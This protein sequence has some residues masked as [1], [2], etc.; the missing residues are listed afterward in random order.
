MLDKRIFVAGH[1]GLAGSAILRR[2]Q[3]E[4]AQNLLTRTRAELDLTRQEAVEAF[5]AQER[6]QVVFLAAAEVGGILANSTRPYDFIAK[7]LLIQ[8]LVFDAC[9]RS[10]VEQVV[11]LGSSCIY[12]RDCAQPIREEYLL[13]GPLETTNDAYAL[14]K[15]AGIRTA[16]ALRQ[17]HGLDAISLMPTNLYGPGDNFDLQGSHVL[18]ALLRKAHEAKLAGADALEVWGSGR[19]LREFLH[20]D[21]LASAC[22]FLAQRY[23][24]PAPINVGSGDEVSIAELA[25][26]ICEV[27]GFEGELRFDASKPDGTPRKL[28]D[29]S[30]LRELGWQP[31]FSL[32]DGIASTYAWFLEQGAGVRVRG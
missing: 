2:L 15:I 13:T 30:R 11:F 32:R 12:P 24:E 27:V 26:T 14:A 9:L 23:H 7:N 16:Q 3:A 25:R 29:T 5:F 8:T 17:Q 6:P 4:G 31:E 10:G 1:R 20:V 22:V 18:P 28:L 19:P 21:D